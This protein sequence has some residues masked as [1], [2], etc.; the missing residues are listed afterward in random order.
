MNV[1][2]LFTFSC[3]FC[4][5]FVECYT[6]EID[7]F[8]Y[9]PGFETEDVISPLE[10][11]EYFPKPRYAKEHSM[12]R[13]YNWVSSIYRL[14]GVDHDSI[15][16]DEEKI[17]RAVAVQKELAEHWNYYFHLGN[18]KKVAKVKLKNKKTDPYASF[19]DFANQHPEIPV[20]ITT[21]WSQL[22]LKTI[23]NA[24]KAP[25]I[26]RQN[27]D[28]S[29]YLKGVKS[30]VG[31]KILSYNAPDSLLAFDGLAQKHLFDKIGQI[32]TR[33]INIINENGETRP[34]KPFKG[35]RFKL[36]KSLNSNFKKSGDANWQVFQSKKKFHFRKIYRDQFLSDTSL[37]KNTKFTWYAVD[38][39][40]KQRFNWEESKRISTPF[41]GNYYAAPDFYP[42]WS[43][44]WYKG[45]GAWHGWRWLEAARK[46]EIKAGDLFFS[47]YVAAGW[48][49]DPSRNIRPSQW[50][51]LLK[52]MGPIGAEFYYAAFFNINKNKIADPKN[53]V[54]QLAMPSY[55]QAVTSRYENLFRA[56]N[57]LQNEAGGYIVSYPN[58]SSE[59]VLVTVRKQENK[60]VYIIAAAIQPSKAES[61]VG[62]PETRA[63]IFIDG[64]SIS[65]TARKQGS[66]YLYNNEDEN[67][68][69]FYQLDGW[70]EIGHP[71]RWSSKIEVEAELFDKSENILF[72][73][74][75]SN[76][77]F[78]DFT[79]SVAAQKEFG[80]LYY[81]CPC[82]NETD[83]NFE[84]RLKTE[85]KS[86]RK[87]SNHPFKLALNG[88]VQ[89]LKYQKSKKNDWTWSSIEPT[90][91]LKC[92][93]GKIEVSI[94]SLK[95]GVW[96]DKFKL[97]PNKSFEE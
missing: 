73:T 8:E 24:Y 93:G 72:K 77:A 92:S 75:T 35:K 69:Y 65:F 27:L 44:N 67:N 22:N 95:P 63:S 37:L 14:G 70:H 43:S 30:R 74:T 76:G 42:R 53:Y 97:S 86:R 32:L 54:W 88:E 19:V 81:E 4:L 12:E 66:V 21:F 41:N 34:H 96:I 84:I 2:V 33:P 79:T 26:K 6:Q 23:G 58:E 61:I 89:N 29:F 85:A 3:F 11:I 56:G 80:S 52:C 1:R 36:D 87:K 45:K 5:S 47:P 7:R 49:A 50:L 38:G 48:D 55:A 51:G 62:V 17:S 20:S 91:K 57:L 78:E 60:K 16:S 18:S 59:K 68:P 46:T 31:F 10:Q 83:Y 39:N 64:D 28:D 71:L 13:N 40:E 25:Y 94:Q 15:V 82:K 90:K 9:P